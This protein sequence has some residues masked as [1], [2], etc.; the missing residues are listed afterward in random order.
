M[1]EVLIPQEE[2]DELVEAR[3]TL[4]SLK[5]FK[6]VCTLLQSILDERYPPDTIVCSDKPHADIGAQLT[7]A[8]RKVAV[9]SERLHDIETSF[10]RTIQEQCDPEKDDRVHCAC[11]YPLRMRIMELEQAMEKVRDVAV[12]VLKKKKEEEEEEVPK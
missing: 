7:A 11:V 12:N 5:T 10:K 4:R 1:R 8:A 3:D 2:Y 6:G 9:I